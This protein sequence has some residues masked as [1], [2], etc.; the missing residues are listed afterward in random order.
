M[1]FHH[2][3]KEGNRLGRRVA[4]YILRHKFCRADEGCRRDDD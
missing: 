1:H 4:D 3:V 2:S